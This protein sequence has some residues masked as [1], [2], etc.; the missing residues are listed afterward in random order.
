M[1]AYVKGWQHPVVYEF[2]IA[3]FGVPPVVR[4]L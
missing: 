3:D 4:N 1:V 2:E